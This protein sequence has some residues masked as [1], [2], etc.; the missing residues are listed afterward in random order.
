MET[1]EVKTK[2]EK[3]N[4]WEFLVIV[5]T[6]DS[7]TEHRVTLDKDYW[8]TLTEEK[9]DPEELVRRSF[10]FLLERE[11]KESILRTF[12]LKVINSYFP[13]YEQEIKNHG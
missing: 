8:E 2:E 7:N 13:E 3:P 6:E 10:I 11:T 9:L 5:G 12:N 1:I 4:G